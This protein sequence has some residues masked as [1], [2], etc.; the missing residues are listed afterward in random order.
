MMASVLLASCALAV[1]IYLIAGH[2]EFWRM[3]E[4]DETD[5][6]AAQ[7]ASWPGVVAVVPARNEA[8]M[9][10]HRITLEALPLSSSTTTATTGQRKLCAQRRQRHLTV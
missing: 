2:G 4:R 6:P 7:P 10:P 3:A 8:D 5:E 1:W 9:V